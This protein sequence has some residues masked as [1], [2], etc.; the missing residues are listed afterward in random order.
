MLDGRSEPSRHAWFIG[1]GA[2][3]RYVGLFSENFNG[4]SLLNT[5]QGRSDGMRPIQD[6]GNDVNVFSAK[7]FDC[8][9]G[10]ID[11][12]QPRSPNDYD[13]KA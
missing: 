3:Y 13:R 7:G 9:Q 11:S 12:S 6:E 2:E 1:E 5:C 10:M 4:R 8:Q